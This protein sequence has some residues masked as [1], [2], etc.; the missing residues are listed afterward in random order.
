MIP[1]G[2]E[3]YRIDV[4]GRYPTPEPESYYLPGLIM[5][6]GGLTGSVAVT[7]DAVSG[8]MWLT[9]TSVPHL[10]DVMDLIKTAL[11]TLHGCR[12][13]F[14]GNINPVDVLKGMQ[15]GVFGTITV[16]EFPKGGHDAEVVQRDPSYVWEPA[17]QTYRLVGYLAA[18]IRINS[19]TTGTKYWM[20]S[21]ATNVDRARLLTHELGN[22]F[23]QVMGLGGSAF[24]D[25]DATNAGSQEFNQGPELECFP[26]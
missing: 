9:T 2:L 19:A 12:N 21:G 7:A 18:D 4:I 6:G 3:V 25:D 24:K 15:E 5:G 14:H 20:G 1:G 26:R 10:D 11:E 8:S 13:L 17:S 22:V 23:N 16:V